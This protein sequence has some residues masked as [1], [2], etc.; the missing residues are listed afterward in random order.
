MD[1]RTPD[2][3]RGPLA[4][5]YRLDR[6]V[7]RGGM[8]SVWLAHDERLGREVAIKRVGHLPG[9][10][11]PHLARAMREARSTAALN[12]RNVV[13][14]YD[15]VE[16]GEHLWLV[17]EY[18]P[19][20]TLSEITAAEGPMDPIRAARIGAQVA[21]GLAAAHALGMVHRDVKPGNI[22]VTDDDVAKIS[23][24]GIARSLADDQ[25]TQTGLMV[26][27]PAYF[28]P[29]L[30]R[31][32]DASPA[33]D[34][35]ALGATLFAAVEG[36]GPYPSQGNALA[37]LAGI[38]TEPPPLP[39]RA[40]PLRQP[41]R[42]MMD[43]DVAAR[44]SMADCAH[45]LHQVNDRHA[46]APVPAPPP[47]RIAVFAAPS[48][49]HLAPVPA[50]VPSAGGAGDRRR[51]TPWVL[52][53]VLVLLLLGGTAWAMTDDDETEPAAADP[54]SSGSSGL[55]GRPQGRQ[56]SAD[57]TPSE[58]AEPEPEPTP[59]EPDDP[60]RGGARAGARP[61]CWEPERLR[62]GLLLPA[63]RRH[64]RGVGDVHR[65]LPVQPRWLRPVRRVLAHHRRRQRRRCRGRR[66]HHRRRVPDLQDR[67]LDP[68]RDPPDLSRAHR[69]RLPDHRR[70]ARLS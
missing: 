50:P 66:R 42:R 65:G 41:I 64:R 18:V 8:G 11:L 22:L 58:S 59:E 16:E 9:E 28:A 2:S 24:F 32:A 33:S 45:A 25:L 3:S 69:R 52:A 35:W 61:R 14:V 63:A 15:A 10:S 46:G 34:V 40:G 26:G 60:G 27:T 47:D 6:E 70:R 44:W 23:D 56:P 38:A 20:R 48:P 68:V 31:G 21:D 55:S 54:R 12:H 51:R 7:G 49:E 4:G 53:A 67:R 62:R 43:T 37:V 57:P 29:E 5:R 19:G 1:P 39:E 13:A 36:H 30:A 17:M